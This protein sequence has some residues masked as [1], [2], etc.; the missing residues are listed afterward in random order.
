MAIVFLVYDLFVQKRN[1][2]LI[3]K[4][5]QTN[6]IVYS[7]FPNKNND[8]GDGKDVEGGDANGNAPDVS[9]T[10]SSQIADD[11]GPQ[12]QRL[13]EGGRSEERG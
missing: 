9:V 5:A 2:N 13:E 8:L 7:L 6:A 3:V 4:A 10:I 1:Y 12:E 11:H